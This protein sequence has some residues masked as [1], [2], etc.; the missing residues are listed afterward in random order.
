MKAIERKICE[1]MPMSTGTC[2]LVYKQNRCM[3]IKA[4]K[5]PHKLKKKKK[6]FHVSSDMKKSLLCLS[7]TVINKSH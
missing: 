6:C 2:A 4:N 1:E 3:Y 5:L 7:S